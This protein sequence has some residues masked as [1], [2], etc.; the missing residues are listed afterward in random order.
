MSSLNLN[1]LRIFAAV[2]RHATLQ[3]A[4]DE[5][6]LTRGAVSQRIKQLEIDLGVVLLQRGARGIT[7]TPEGQR[8]RTAVGTAMAALDTVA[9]EFA[10][11]GQQVTLHLGPSTAARWLMPR[12]DDFAAQ[13]PR[14]SLRTE[15]HDRPMAR[16]L[17][18]HEI[19]LWPG[20]AGATAHFG[21]SRALTDLRLVA[22]CS[23]KLTRPDLTRLDGPLD[24]NSLCRLPLLQDA[25]RHWDRLMAAAGLR[26]GHR[27]MNFD[28]SALALDAAVAGH[29]AA[30]APRYLA[31]DDLTAG[32]LVQ[33][34]IDPA[35]ANEWLF[36]SWSPDP[37]PGPQVQRILD[38]IAD[39]FLPMDPQDMPRA[40]TG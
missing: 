3:G 4:A 10:Q 2:A 40:S 1:S 18:R 7:L 33:V 13:F 14:V 5:L 15:A 11:T 31:R 8:L 38:W 22:V 34:W 26:A 16:A 35:P 9:A 37:A 24:L 19:A 39:Q 20:R 6:N 28:R 36:M 30:L 17:A 12:L 32:R 25:H 23:P 29:G 27:V 21:A